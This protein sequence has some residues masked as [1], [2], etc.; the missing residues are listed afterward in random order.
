MTLSKRDRDRLEV[1]V[2]HLRQGPAPSISRTRKAWED[3]RPWLDSWV[4]TMLD[5]VLAGD[6]DDYFE[7][8]EREM[9][10][11]R[12]AVNEKQEG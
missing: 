1:A 10:R 7:R 12:K 4:L 2:M 5:R 6:P 3:M 11:K 9:V 8:R